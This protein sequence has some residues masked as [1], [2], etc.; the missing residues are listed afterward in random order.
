MKLKLL[1]TV[2]VGASFA[3]VTDGSTLPGVPSTVPSFGVSVNAG[4]SLPASTSARPAA[5]NVT[6]P[7]PSSA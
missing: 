6:L 1:V 4:R 5:V 2:S 7:R 3:G